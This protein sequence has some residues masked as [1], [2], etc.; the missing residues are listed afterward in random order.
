MLPRCLLYGII[1]DDADG[2]AGFLVVEDVVRAE[3]AE[4]LEGRATPLGLVVVPL[5]A[6]LVFAPVK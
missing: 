2:V 5:L 6:A 3:A 1:L 4:V